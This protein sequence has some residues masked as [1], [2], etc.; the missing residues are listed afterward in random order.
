MQVYHSYGDKSNDVLLLFYG[1]VEMQNINDVY[2]AD[3]AEYVQQ[4]VNVDQERWQF[5][6]TDFLVMQSLHQ[7]SLHLL[8]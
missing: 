4:N 8:W 5:L 2:L 7:V 6:E 1:F 3:L